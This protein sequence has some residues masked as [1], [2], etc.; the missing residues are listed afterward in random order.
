MDGYALARLMREISRPG[1]RVRLIG[2][3]AD[4]HGPASRRGV[5]ARFDTILVKPLDPQAL[6][7]ALDRLTRPEAPA[8]ETGADAV[9]RRFGLSGRPRVLICPTPGAAEAAAFSQAFVPVACAAEADLILLSGK[10]GLPG[11]RAARAGTPTRPVPSVDLAGRLAGAC[12]V[13]F[14]VG[15]PASWAAVAEACTGFSAR[16]A[17][18]A[19]GEGPA[20]PVTHLLALLHASA[21]DLPLAGG[22]GGLV[23]ECGLSPA[24]LMAAVLI[25]TEAGALSC[26]AAGTGVSV[27][28][29]EAAIRAATTGILPG[30]PRRPAEPPRPPVLDAH[31][32]AELTRLIGEAEVG[33]RRDRLI[34][35]L[36]T[37]FAPQTDLATLAHEAHLMMAMAGSL[38]FEDLV[39]ACRALE[40]A[41][42]AGTGLAEAV[43]EARRAVAD[44]RSHCAAA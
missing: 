11:L 23:D 19:S 16:R 20:D 4:R 37:A 40:A 34:G 6:Y 9:W 27:R 33:R 13:A 8:P 1:D 35:Q 17:G 15:E 43:T 24:A 44:A 22:E 10:V 12:D 41:I 18:L 30:A 2:V 42:T 25:L 38:G 31:K 26:V 5:D 36:A 7:A 3:T 21:R 32:T 28:L 39:A 29:T 14:R